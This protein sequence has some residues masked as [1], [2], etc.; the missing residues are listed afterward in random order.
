MASSSS[1]RDQVDLDR[2][3]ALADDEAAGTEGVLGK[4]VFY[5][6]AD[7]IRIARDEL[8]RLFAIHQIPDGYLPEPIKPASV[9]GSLLKGKKVEVAIEGRRHQVAFH[10]EPKADGALEA[11]LT[12]TRRRT[13]LERKGGAGE[14]EVVTVATLVWSPEDASKIYWAVVDGLAHEYDYA[15][16]L[17]EIETEFEER[18]QFYGRDKISQF[19][20]RILNNTMSVR[21]RPTGGVWLV[22]ISA[23]ELLERVEQLVRLLDSQYRREGD[24]NGET[25]F[26]S[27]LLVDREKNRIFVRSKVEE[28]I[29]ADL[30][31]AVA[32][33]LALSQAGVRVNPSDLAGP[34]EIRKRAL[35]YRDEFGVVMAGEESEA[36]ARALDDFDLAYGQAT[37][38]R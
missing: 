11:L 28:R 13:E 16:I 36:L 29:L 27:I 14:W 22:P 8:E 34:A 17:S 21:T 32:G 19:V 6:I 10:V 5:A 31:E 24:D 30:R 12:R 37:A 35:R 23:M 33:L 4:I 38:L 7:T 15:G 26:D 2:V 25:E 20:G 1:I 18:R 3:A 9:I